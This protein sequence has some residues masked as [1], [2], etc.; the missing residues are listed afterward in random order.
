MAIGGTKTG[1]YEG[2]D[3]GGVS[4]EAKPGMLKVRIFGE[5]YSVW[6]LHCEW[7]WKCTDCVFSGKIKCEPRFWGE[8]WEQ[9]PQIVERHCIYDG[10]VFSIDRKELKKG[11]GMCCSTSCIAR[12][13]IE[14]GLFPTQPRLGEMV[15]CHE[16]GKLKYQQR[17][18]LEAGRKYFCCRS[19]QSRHL[20]KKYGFGAHPENR[21]RGRLVAVA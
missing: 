13:K 3:V 7:R 6:P 20:G 19:H 1:H 15:A 4:Q 11:R 17:C 21:G 14:L 8:G 18:D 16:C 5:D 9:L 10:T 2:Y 12:L